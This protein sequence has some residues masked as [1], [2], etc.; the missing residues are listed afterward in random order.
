VQEVLLRETPIQI[1]GTPATESFRQSGDGLQVVE[2]RV[3]SRNVRVTITSP[4]AAF[5]AHL[6]EF[7][8]YIVG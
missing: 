7:D 2:I 3:P 6:A 8:A 1:D 4:D 5:A